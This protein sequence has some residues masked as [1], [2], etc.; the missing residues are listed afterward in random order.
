VTLPHLLAGPI[1]RRTESTRVTIWLATTDSVSLSGELL[2]LPG[3]ARSE[4]V[5]IASAGARSARLGPR[6]AVH[7]VSLTPD[8]GVFP[9][10]QLL[11]YDIHVHGGRDRA[12]PQSLAS[13]GLLR[14]DRSLSYDGFPLPTVCIR[15]ATPALTLM[16]GSCRLLHGA[17]EDALVAADEAIAGVAHDIGQ[18]PSAMFLTGDQIYADDVAAPIIGHIRRLATQLMGRRDETSVPDMPSLGE[19][20]VDGRSDLISARARFTSERAGNHLVSFGEFAAM[21][22]MAW[23]EAVW[24][25]AFPSGAE[26]ARDQRSSPA[27]LR[28][29]R[30]YDRQRRYLEGARRALPSVRRVLANTPTYMNFDDHDTTD[31]WNLTQSWRDRVHDSPAGRRIVANA[32]AAYWAFQGWGNDPDSYDDAFVATISAFLTGGA[33]SAEEFEDLLWS[34]DRWSYLAP[35]EPPT[36]VLDTRTQRGYDSPDGGARLLGMEARARVAELVRRSGYR[37]EDPLIVVSAVPVFGF[38]LQERRQ[39]YLVDKLGPYE[40]DFE[41]WHS[42]LRG[43]VDL[44]QLLVEDIDPSSCIL[45]SGDVH[46]GV[47]ARASFVIEDHVLL[48]TQLVSSGLKHASPAAKAALNTLGRLLRLKHQRLGWDG[49]PEGKRQNKL[50]DR[51][52]LRAVNTDEWTDDSPVFL[53]PRD[54]KLLGIEQDPDFRECRIYVR[55]RGRNSSI[56]VGENN[57]GLVQV[58]GEEVTHR[59]LARGKNRTRAHVATITLNTEGLV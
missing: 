27:R 51:I 22:L 3:D 24:P 20:P 18:R 35:T 57:C 12:E 37:R 21:Y 28:A 47:N 48:F 30:K 4:P 45:L 58:E 17:G 42:N 29:A 31:D 23:N 50:A 43:L 49:P 2:R 26:L 25:D 13:L 59:L 10:D 41:A 56:L 11:A 54:V 52:M 44:M 55:P 19:L 8:E 40:I 38:E 14:G 32:L 6:L 15:E 1:V 9:T 36:I 7:L 53:A 33:T 39:K 16:H 34:F 46:Y 5:P